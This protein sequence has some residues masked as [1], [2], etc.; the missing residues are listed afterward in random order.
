MIESVAI[1]NARKRSEQARKEWWLNAPSPIDSAAK[2]ATEHALNDYT[3][4]PDDI[5]STEKG[6][7]QFRRWSAADARTAQFS[8]VAPP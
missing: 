8:L 6:L 1:D 3:L 4:Q 2:I 5:V 7:L